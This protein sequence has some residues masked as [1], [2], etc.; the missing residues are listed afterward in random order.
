MS[1]DKP[2]LMFD[3]HVLSLGECLLTRLVELA[4]HADDL[5][6]SLDLP[7]PDVGDQAMDLVITAL[8]RI[9]RQRHGSLAILRAFSRRERMSSNVAAF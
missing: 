6:V 1:V 2:V 4:V 7:T 3:R 9:S 5:A 8:S